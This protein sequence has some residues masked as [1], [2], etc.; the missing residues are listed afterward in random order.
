[1]FI[2]KYGP[3]LSEIVSS[4]KNKD[5]FQIINSKKDLQAMPAECNVILTVDKGSL[6]A[7]CREPLIIYIFRC[8]DIGHPCSYP[9]ASC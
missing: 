5:I 9:S 3:G 8:L 4:Q 1:M 7:M 6:E 2:F